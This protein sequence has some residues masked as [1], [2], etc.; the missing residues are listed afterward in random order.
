M[1]FKYFIQRV[2]YVFI[3]Y[4]WTNFTQI[5][6][7]ND[8]NTKL[9]IGIFLINQFWDTNWVSI[10]WHHNIVYNTI[11]RIFKND[12]RKYSFGMHGFDIEIYII[13]SSASASGVIMT[14]WNIHLERTYN[15]SNKTLR[16]CKFFYV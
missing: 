2:N 9:F 15:V 1:I 16:T 5:L 12:P 10:L 6:F 7:Y 8:C 4:I 3:E 13:L 14:F 11:T